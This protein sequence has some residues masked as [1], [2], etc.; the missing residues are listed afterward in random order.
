MPKIDQATIGA[1]LIPVPDRRVQDRI[2]AELAE[3]EAVSSQLDRDL[4]AAVVESTA[5]RRSLLEAAFSGRLT[6][7]ASCVDRVQEPR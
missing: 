2:V 5:L 1:T 4:S 6:G 3:A 7:H